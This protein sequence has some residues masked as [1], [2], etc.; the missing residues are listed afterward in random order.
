MAE[1]HSAFGLVIIAATALF[2]LVA[3]GLAF[4]SGATTWLEWARTGLFV[5]IGIQLVIGVVV[6]GTGHRPQEPLHLL[7]GAVLFGALPLASTFSAEAPRKPR[8]A[9]LAVAGVVM[10]LVLWR[11]VETG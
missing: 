9:V 1:V 11:L 5:L 6:Y 8:S 4:S 3:G 10:L 2:T 7:Y